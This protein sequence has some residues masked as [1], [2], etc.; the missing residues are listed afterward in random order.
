MTPKVIRCGETDRRARVRK[1][2]AG[3]SA[4]KRSFANGYSEGERAGK[5]QGEEFVQ[6]AARRYDQQTAEMVSAYRKLAESLETTMRQLVV[7]VAKT[8]V[9]RELSVR[10]EDL[11]AL[12]LEALG[13]V[14]FQPDIVLR[15]SREDY[16]R[17]RDAVA[18]A[19]P[20][21][22]VTEDSS[23]EIGDFV[24]DTA[25]TH[26]DGRIASQVETLGRS[27]G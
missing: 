18:A 20:A 4:E 25:L 11:E 16:P 21:V 23:L 24:V 19:N 1:P 13:R 3:D 2:E 12:V 26:L 7:E 27:L 17:V 9:R 10:P 22:T 6:A 14:K 15:V 8:V 5:K